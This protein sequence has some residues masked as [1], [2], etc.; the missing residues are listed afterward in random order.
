MI[1][2]SNNGERY[3]LDRLVFKTSLLGVRPYR[4]YH[5]HEYGHPSSIDID[6]LYWPAP[7]TETWYQIDGV[8]NLPSHLTFHCVIQV[9]FKCYQ[10]L[11]SHLS[12]QFSQGAAFPLYIRIWVCKENSNLNLNLRMRGKLKFE[13]VAQV[14]VIIY[15]YIKF[16]L[17]N[18]KFFCDFGP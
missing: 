6:R 10:C 13:F 4:F 5:A 7:M 18:Y 3:I 2:P 17:R 9:L 14:C 16:I 11:G 15:I 1:S 12:Y 8:G